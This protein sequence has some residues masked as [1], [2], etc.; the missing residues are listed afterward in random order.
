M[1]TGSVYEVLEYDLDTG[2]VDGVFLTTALGPSEHMS[3][4]EVIGHWPQIR[5]LG[6]AFLLQMDLCA[7]AAH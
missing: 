6:R 7:S 4:A 1:S 5:E 3:A 2:E